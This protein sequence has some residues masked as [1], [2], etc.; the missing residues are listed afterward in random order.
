MAVTPEIIQQLAPTGTLRAAINMSNFLLVVDKAANGD[1]IGPSP[2]VAAAVAGALGV[3]LKLVP[4][5]T[6]SDI[7]A[8]AGTGVW[9]IANI[10][11]EPQRAAVIDFTAPYAEIEACYLVPAGSTIEAIDEVDQPGKTISV[12]AGSAYGLWLE[13]NVQH[14]DLRA[15]KGNAY[16]QF[17]NDGLDALAGLRS[18]LVKDVAR[19]PGSRILDGQFTAVQQAVGINKDLDAALAWVEVFV[20]EIKANGLITALIDEHGVTGQLSVAPLSDL[21]G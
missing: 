18:Q 14:A 15:I 19:L 1:P 10:G 20:E 8:A 2:G 5:R 11:A 16:E 12:S 7:A 13:N 9:D 6:P 3:P 4:F 21:A 17:V